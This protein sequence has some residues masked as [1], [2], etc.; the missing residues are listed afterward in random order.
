MRIQSAKQVVEVLFDGSCGLCRREIDL[1]RRTKVGAD[2][3]RTKFI[4]IASRD[5]N[6]E[7]KVN[8][9]KEQVKSVDELLAEMHVFDVTSGVMHKRVNAFR[10]L[11][12]HLGA[13]GFLVQW[14]SIYP[15]NIILDSSY[16]LFLKYIRPVLSRAVS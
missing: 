5:F 4:N 13:P 16:T 3:T 11:Y 1:L 12:L 14:T 2:A 15:F 6:F 8:T 9:W 10:H 7:E